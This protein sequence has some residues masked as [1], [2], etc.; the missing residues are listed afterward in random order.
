LP[1]DEEVKGEGEKGK[2][3]AKNNGGEGKRLFRKLKRMKWSGRGLSPRKKTLS[4]FSGGWE[5]QAAHKKRG[6]GKRKGKT[7]TA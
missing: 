3:G 4:S 7:K 5:P 2:E 1:M 6:K